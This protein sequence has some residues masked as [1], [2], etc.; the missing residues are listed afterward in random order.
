VKCL[1][2]LQQR[3]REL[4]GE[5]LALIEPVL[6]RTGCWDSFAKA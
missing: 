4:G 1:D 2:R 3:F 5:D 6:R